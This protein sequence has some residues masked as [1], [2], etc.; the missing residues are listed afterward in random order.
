[1][2]K[3]GN[4]TER[5]AVVAIVEWAAIE[6]AFAGEGLVGAGGALLLGN[7]FSTNIWSAFGYRTLLEESGLDGTAL[8]LFGDR[9]N[10]ETVLAELSTAR[11]V[12]GVAT[13]T[14]KR[15]LALLGG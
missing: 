12:L 13:P 14:E 6:E 11:R 7:G 9:T 2:R 1:M 3:Y 4:V 8:S 5:D 15:L 10:F